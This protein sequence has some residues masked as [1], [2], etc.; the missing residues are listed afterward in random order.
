MGERLLCT[1]EV[2]GSNPLTSID[3]RPADWFYGFVLI[4]KRFIHPVWLL[5]L[6][7]T[8]FIIIAGSY[9]SPHGL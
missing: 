9:G 3:G 7:V 8:G 1:Q 4:A 6:S 2:S 5:T